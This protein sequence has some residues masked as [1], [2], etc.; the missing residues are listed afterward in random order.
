MVTILMDGKR[1][2]TTNLVIIVADNGEDEL[3]IIPDQFD[4]KLKL[5]FNHC[6][7]GG[8]SDTLKK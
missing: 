6:K 8:K 7:Y 2:T 4:K 5:S 3:W 1:I